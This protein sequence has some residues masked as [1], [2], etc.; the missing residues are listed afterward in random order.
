MH[1]GL[2]RDVLVYASGDVATRA[3][4][5]ISV[6]IYTHIFQPEQF[7][8]L[9]FVSTIGTLAAGIAIVGGD[10]VLARFWFQDQSLEGH[11]RLITTWIGFLAVSGLLVS[12]V[13]SAAV[14]LFARALLEDQSG[15][16]LLWLVLATMPVANVNRMLAQVMRNQ[17]RPVPYAVTS[18]ILGLV[19]LSIGLY[20]VLQLGLG[21]SGI[22]AGVLIAEL[23]VL[24]VRAVIVREV[25]VGDFDAKL[26]RKLLRF[27][28]PLVPV[29]MS[30]WV[31]T[32]SD[33][34]VLAKLGSF[35]DLGFYSAALS[36][37][38]FLA[39][40]NAAV[41]QAWAPRMYQLYER[42]PDG[43]STVVGVSLT[44]YIFGLGLLAVA[45]SAVA[46]EVINLLTA[47][48]YAPSA[49]VVPYLA[50]GA[51]AYGSSLVTS[52]G[53]TMTYRTGRLSTYSALAAAGNVVLAIVLV[54][55]FGMIGAALASLLGYTVLSS[56]YFLASQ[57][58]WRMR[59]EPRRLIS[60]LVIL[61]ACVLASAALRTA[62]VTLRL[63][64]PIG[65]LV[66]LG[67]VAGVNDRDRRIFGRM[68]GA[69][70]DSS[71]SR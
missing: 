27:G 49:K 45:V 18:F 11:R 64:I 2:P 47:D 65:Y 12:L 23:L 28:V 34:I 30:F 17:F 39:L 63:F 56:A 57:R 33:R 20:S 26:L 21:V 38:S 19:A 58:V 3:L 31:F 60:T 6:P 61:T 43:A 7:S 66:L 67:L 8:R 22:L 13:A 15:A 48:A 24:I 1:H 29:T 70:R 9:A 53:L 42:D 44:Y 5:F 14:P 68:C 59:L 10:T 71:G 37:V 46:P 54:P 36:L 32:A 50:L 62:P 4:G 16:I 35:A 40:L 41:G 51:V 25:L 69:V 52:S 55:W